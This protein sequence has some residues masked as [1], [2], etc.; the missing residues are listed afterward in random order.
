MTVI[1]VLAMAYGSSWQELVYVG[2]V[3]ILDPPRE[4]VREAV[5]TLLS[6]GTALKMVTGD[7]EETA[8]AIG[9]LREQMEC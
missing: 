2:C 5:E 7:A 6:T 4:G 9:M 1:S 3:G 8:I